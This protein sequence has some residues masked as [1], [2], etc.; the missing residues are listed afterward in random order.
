MSSTHPPEVS[1][2]SEDEPAITA[3][4]SIASDTELHASAAVSAASE[5]EPAITAA[6]S[7]VSEG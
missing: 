2:A 5:D 6:S 4:S 7:I 3:A 1:T